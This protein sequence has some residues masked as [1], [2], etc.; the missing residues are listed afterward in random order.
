MKSI[1]VSKTLV[2][3]VLGAATLGLLPAAAVAQSM[4]SMQYNPYAWMNHMNDIG[5][6]QAQQMY[7]LCLHNPGA[8]NGLATPQSL[9]DAINGVQQQSLY[10][11]RQTQ[12]NMRNSW[13][14]V[15]QTNCAITGGHVY[16]NPNTLQNECY[17]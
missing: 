14:S 4:P 12:Q 5:N 16:Y 2:A 1:L 9:N 11:S 13:Q 15:S 3:L 17:R 7:Y 6:R 8:C 10:N